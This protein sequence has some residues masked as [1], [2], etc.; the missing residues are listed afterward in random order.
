MEDKKLNIIVLAGGESG[1]RDVS[2]ESARAIAASLISTGNSVRIIDTLSGEFF[3]ESFIH[4]TEK[5]ASEDYSIPEGAQEKGMEKLIGNLSEARD[6]GLD[7]A[8]NGL[9]GGFGE[10]GTFQ[11]IMEFLQIPYTGSPMAASAIAMNKDISKR[12]MKTLNIPTAYWKVF[13][14]GQQVVGMVNQISTQFDI[15]VII[16]PVDC[17]S[18][19][20]LSLVEDLGDL[21]PAFEKAFGAS[22][23]IM[24]ETYYSGQEIT[25]AVLNGL[26]LPPVEIKPTHK[27]YDYTCKYTKGKSQYFCPANISDE[28]ADRLSD[29]ASRFYQTIGCRGY[30]RVDFIV[31]DVDDYICLELNTLPG[32]TE[33]SL[34]PMAAKEAGIS[35]DELLVNLCHLALDKE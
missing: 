9:H 25:I 14:S 32:M 2:L 28:L 12:I 20:G 30:A 7:V 31:K 6:N 29:D 18:T 11:A 1:E 15:P 35:F 19:V 5:I 33:L 17:G 24:A 4:G 16:K 21:A 3:E 8:F 27:L 26:T 10:N 34:F 23:Q 22:H 13:E